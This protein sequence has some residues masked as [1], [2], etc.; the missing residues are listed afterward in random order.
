MV[1]NDPQRTT[2]G[3][4][5]VKVTTSTVH[6]DRVADLRSLWVVN[7]S[8]DSPIGGILSVALVC[9]VLLSGVLHIRI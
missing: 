5:I 9:F 3:P 1:Y 8:A 6:R 7:D 2:I 4:A